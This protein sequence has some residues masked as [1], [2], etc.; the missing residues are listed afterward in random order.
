[1]RSTFNGLATSDELIRSKPDL[2]LR[3]VRATV[4]GMTYTRLNRE[5]SIARFVKDLKATPEGAA[6]GYDQ[7]R[8]LMAETATIS[9][10]AQATELSLR[11]DML[12]VAADKLPPIAGVF[13][14]SF[15]DKVAAEIK[16]EGWTPAP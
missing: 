15:A 14:F 10:E 3:F 2:V 4:K 12:N 5:A 1:M 16:A 13:D 6:T 11:G 8:P 7:L 9:K